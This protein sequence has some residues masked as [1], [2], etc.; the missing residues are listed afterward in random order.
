V[1]FLQDMVVVT[2]KMLTT[3]RLTM[4]SMN[5]VWI[6]LFS[7]IARYVIDCHISY[8]NGVCHNRLYLYFIYS[9]S[10]KT[11]KNLSI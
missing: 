9:S 5:T 4:S 10:Q 8:L 11:V 6:K 1:Y 2:T 7:T 3:N